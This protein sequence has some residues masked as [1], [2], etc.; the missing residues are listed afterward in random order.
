MP[1]IREVMSDCAVSIRAEDTLTDA[2]KVLCR[3]HLSGAPVVS[4]SGEVVG[5]ISETELMDVVFDDAVR[6]EPVSA[7]MSRDNQV[8]HPDDSITAAA[9]LFALYGVRRLP[10]VDQG[11]LVG[12]VT[13]RDLLQYSLSGA[14]PVTDPLVELIPSLGQFA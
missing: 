5:F 4:A 1:T 13:R 12:V 11:T 3:H 6:L 10:V 2:V 14:Q 9:A 7:F 8:V